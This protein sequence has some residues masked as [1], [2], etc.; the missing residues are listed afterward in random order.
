MYFMKKPLKMFFVS[1]L[2]PLTL[3]LGACGTTERTKDVTATVI[4]KDYD[5]PT[6]KKVRVSNATTP[7]SN[8]INSVESVKASTSSSRSRARTSSSKSSSWGSTNSKPKVSNSTSSS[9]KSTSTTK[10]P[11]TT[12]S[13]TKSSTTYK[14]VTSS[15]TKKSKPVYKTVRKPAEYDVLLRYKDLEVEVDDKSLYK[16]VRIGSKVRVELIEVVDDD[17]K[18]VV[19]SFLRYRD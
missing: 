3:L 5:A 18:K 2:I 1:T 9:N 15:N 10:K 12:S 4:E 8:S 11:T 16:S 19:R 7:A 13:T 14:P 17:T 6:T